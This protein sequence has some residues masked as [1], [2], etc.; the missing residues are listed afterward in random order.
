[1]PGGST[2]PC[3]QPLTVTG[4]SRVPSARCAIQP[5]LMLS[6]TTSTRDVSDAGTLTSR[7]ALLQVPVCAGT[8]AA[9]R[10]RPASGPAS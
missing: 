6:G 2:Q 8:V 1:M 3:C 4:V 5:G 9:G 7:S 10:I